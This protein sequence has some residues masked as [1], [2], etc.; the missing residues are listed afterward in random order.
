MALKKPV[1]NSLKFFNYLFSGMLCSLPKGSLK[2]E[3]DVVRICIDKIRN[4]PITKI[5]IVKIYLNQ[6]K[7]NIICL[8]LL[9]LYC[10][11]LNIVHSK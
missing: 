2:S 3:I 1:Q 8:L 10:I 11:S 6:Y 4:R 7:R 9:F 5:F